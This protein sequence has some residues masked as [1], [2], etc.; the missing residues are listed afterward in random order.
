[1]VSP[2]LLHPN[3]PA[4]GADRDIAVAVFPN[5]ICPADFKLN[6]PRRMRRDEHIIFQAALIAVIDDIDARI[7]VA[8]LHARKI[9]DVLN[10]SARIGSAEVVGAA[11]LKIQALNRGVAIPAGT[12]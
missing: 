3:G 10:P 6:R 5:A 11:G 12:S 2:W 9:R 4:T 7:D 8:V 1:L